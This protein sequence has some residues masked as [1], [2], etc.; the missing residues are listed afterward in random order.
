MWRKVYKIF[1]TLMF[2]FGA[3]PL[4][5]SAV[6]GESDSKAMVFL[7]FVVIFAISYYIG[8]FLLF[9]RRK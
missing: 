7:S 1:G 4:L 3:F 5:F 2:I 6:F 8:Y 9:G